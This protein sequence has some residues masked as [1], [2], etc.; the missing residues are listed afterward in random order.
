MGMNRRSWGEAGRQF[1]RL[2][3]FGH[4]MVLGEMDFGSISVVAFSFFLAFS[5]ISSHVL[6]FCLVDFCSPGTLSMSHS[7]I[8]ASFNKHMGLESLFS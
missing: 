5:S 2:G 8:P 3:Y 4:D 7:D 1:V 6:P